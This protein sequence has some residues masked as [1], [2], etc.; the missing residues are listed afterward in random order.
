MMPIAI[1]CSRVS[2]CPSTKVECYYSHVLQETIDHYNYCDILWTIK[3]NKMNIALPVKKRKNKNKL[4]ILTTSTRL[5]KYR[6][7]DSPQVQ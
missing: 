1:I 2:F 6:I 4:V 5:H 3:T 7:L